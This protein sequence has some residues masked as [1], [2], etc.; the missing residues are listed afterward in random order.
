MSL[1]G[2]LRTSVSGMTAQSN[3]LGTVSDN[4][5]NAG[6]AGYKR[7]DTQFSSLLLETGGTEYQSGSVNTDVRYAISQ[8]GALNYTSSSTDLAV[9]GSGF[10]LVT[11]PSGQTQL[12][13]AGSFQVDA[14]TGNLVN[15]AGL[16][17]MGYDVSAGDPN[18]VLNGTA[19][20]VPI[21][22]QNTKLAATPSTEGTFA[23]NLPSN[24]AV[25]AAPNAG[26]N[27]AGASF[28]EKSSL[29]AYDNLGNAVTLDLYL[30]KTAASPDTWQLAVYDRA[31]APATGTFPY[32]SGPLSTQTLSFDATGKL[33]SGNSISLAV[34]NG[35][36][37]TLDLAGMSQLAAPYTP[38]T[39]SVNGN[40]PSAISDFSIAKDGIVYATDANGR[41]SAIYRIPLGT[42][43]S[44]DRLEPL[45]GNAYT[46]TLES[47]AIQIGFPNEGGVG[48][49]LSGATEQSNV[50]M[51]SELT[52]MIV[53]QRDYTANSKVFQTGTELL[54]VLMNLKR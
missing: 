30:T 5:A 43:Q 27:V 32:A 22:L 20:L 3:L 14:S 4:I 52:R 26:A 45:T 51:A 46:T 18:V 11:D 47:G 37:L 24:A 17:L 19:G 33:A 28:S 39:A 13:R 50:D 36:T 16:T 15:S 54:D 42:V 12:T 53:A 7:A 41:K 40:A 2:M 29:V 31:G 1:Y 10:F 48:T 9:Q 8:Q 38:F 44:A 25:A 23:A 49:L 35:A 34:P 6:T 21:N